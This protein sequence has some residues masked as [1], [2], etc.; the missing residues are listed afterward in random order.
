M[1][2]TASMLIPTGM[3]VQVRRLL[4]VGSGGAELQQEWCAAR[5]HEP[6]RHMGP[7]Q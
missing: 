5:R 7:K 4:R 6:E 2:M 1:R 3:G